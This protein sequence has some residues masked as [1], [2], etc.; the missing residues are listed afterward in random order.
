VLAIY[1]LY[2]IYTIYVHADM[3]YTTVLLSNRIK[4]HATQCCKGINQFT[5]L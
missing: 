5:V 2:Y 1:L 4:F 3:L